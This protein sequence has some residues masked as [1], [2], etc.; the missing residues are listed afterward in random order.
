[1][2]IHEL[3]NMFKRTREPYEYLKCSELH[4]SLPFISFFFPSN[5]C[6]ADVTLETDMLLSLLQSPVTWQTLS[7]KLSS[8][9][10][11]TSHH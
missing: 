6:G 1:M 4:L 7:V 2:N 3:R 9:R 11:L 8:G 5:L 10:C